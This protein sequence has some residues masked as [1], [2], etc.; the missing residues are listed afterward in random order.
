MT[1]ADIQLL[2]DFYKVG[3]RQG[4]GSQEVTLQA[5]ALTGIEKGSDIEIADIGCGTGGQ[6]ITLA[7]HTSGTITGIDLFPGFL[8]ILE[9]Q[10]KALGIADR[11]KTKVQSMDQLDFE[12]ESLDVIWSE[13]AIYNIGFEKGVND[14]RPF[15]KPGGYLA[16]SEISWITSSRPREIQDFWEAAYPEIGAI[17]EKI[18]ALEQSGYTPVAHFILPPHCW[19]DNYYDPLEGRFASFLEQYPNVPMALQ[20]VEE[21]KE[22]IALYK[23][24]K[25][26]YSYGFY[27]AKK[28]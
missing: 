7:Q 28:C 15:L 10:A 3:A 25:D 2:V 27:L 9:R 26:Y 24:Y 5:L 16:V 21:T 18:A 22:E 13:G 4:P 1:E 8:D 11:I 14:W 6:T 12:E 19:T 17:S 20:L 23:K